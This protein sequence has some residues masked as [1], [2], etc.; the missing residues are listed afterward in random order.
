MIYG[1]ATNDLPD[2]K[3]QIVEYYKDETG[4]TKRKVIWSCPFYTKWFNMISRC[5]N[6]YEHVRHP[7]YEK[8]LFVKNGF[9]SLNLKLGW[10]HKIL[11]GNS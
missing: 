2:H 5:Y 4:K 1:V 6:P 7:L 8:L 10:R 9:I 3:T 11:K